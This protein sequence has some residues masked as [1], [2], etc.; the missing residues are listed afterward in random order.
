MDERVKVLVVDDDLRLTRT[1]HDILEIKGYKAAEAH[2]GE[3][4][5][6]RIASDPPDFVL[7]D[8]RMP[9]LDGI[10]TL[11]IIKHT[12]PDIPVALMSAFATDEQASEARAL[13]VYSI[14]GK[15]V[16]I[17]AFLALLAVLQKVGVLD[18]PG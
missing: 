18:K 16:D 6:E 11:K 9:G 10:E 12:V 2:T 15:P 3:E 13:G 17:P 14:L 7:M 5:L 8:L 4:A 1:M